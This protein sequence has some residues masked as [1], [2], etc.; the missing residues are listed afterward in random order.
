MKLIEI[1]A[2]L[3]I[4]TM[5]LSAM[6]SAAQEIVVEAE[7]HSPFNYFDKERCSVEVNFHPFIFIE[8]RHLP[9]MRT[10]FA[11]FDDRGFTGYYREKNKKEKIDLDNSRAE[12]FFMTILGFHKETTAIQ[13]KQ[14]L[15]K[16]HNT[17]NTTTQ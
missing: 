17:L 13:K 16:L 6:E 10:Y 12:A 4:S 1:F 5:Q 14:L 2:L 3:F 9:T 8:A 15:D 11:S 7:E